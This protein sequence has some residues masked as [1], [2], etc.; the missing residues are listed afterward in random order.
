MQAAQ[1]RWFEDFR[2]GDV[3]EFGDDELT[4]AEII[5]F[6]ER[7]DPQIFHTDPEAAQASP[8]GGLI[9]S[10]W[11]TASV[12]MRLLVDH[13]IPANAS[14]GS[15]GVDELRWKLPVRPGDRLRVRV[16]VQ[17]AMGSRSRPDRGVVRMFTEV[18]NQRGEV[19]MTSHGMLLFRRRPPA[20][21]G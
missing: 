2:P 5:A 16:T 3:A 18:L 13:F 21:E 20:A 4:Q 14:L 10:G 6:A 8:Y 12:M 7:Y 11:Q 1:E 19:V 17:D 15:P 9:A